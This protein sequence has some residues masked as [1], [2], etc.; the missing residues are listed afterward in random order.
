MPIRGARVERPIAHHE[1]GAADAA[2]EHARQEVLARSAGAAAP[3]AQ[4]AAHECARALALLGLARLH[5]LPQLGRDDAQPFIVR[6]V[7]RPAVACDTTFRAVGGATPPRRAPP[8][9]APDI[10][11]VVQNAGATLHVAVNGAREPPRLA[12]RLA[13]P[14]RARGGHSVR[15]QIRASSDVRYLAELR[16]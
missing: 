6:L 11:H 16:R 15:V 12:P 9:E 13:L 8:R 3:F 10:S 14:T 1:A 4:P 5:L 7:E 2:H